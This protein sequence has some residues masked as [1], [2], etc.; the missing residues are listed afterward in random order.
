MSRLSA[1]GRQVARALRSPF[2]WPAGR[3]GSPLLLGYVIP[4]GEEIHNSLTRLQLALLK[5]HGS[6]LRL[7][8]S[9]HITLKQAF[10][11][12]DVGP[13]ERYFD[14]LVDEVDPF[15]I[16][17]RDVGFFEEGIIYA[18]VEHSTE[19][20]ALRARLL[21][22]LSNEFGVQPYPIEDERYHFHATLAYDVPSR[23]LERARRALKGV[24]IDLQFSCEALDLICHT[25]RDW[26]T[27]RHSTLARTRRHPAGQPCASG[28]T[29]GPSA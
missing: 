8:T 17:V 9:P 16:R 29:W 19:L 13:F 12:K 10:Q 27:Y 22:D 11:T 23:S 18:D 25:R 15:D 3:A 20:D 28:P 14:R 2:T 21:R 4:V 6:D 1:V 24:R 5:D 7:E 26:I